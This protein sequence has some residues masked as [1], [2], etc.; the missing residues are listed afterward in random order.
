MSFPPMPMIPPMINLAGAAQGIDQIDDRNVTIHGRINEPQMMALQKILIQ[1]DHK[2]TQDKKAYQQHL[3]L[4][5]QSEAKKD[6]KEVIVMDVKN[7][8]KQNLFNLPNLFQTFTFNPEYKTV[9][10]DPDSRGPLYLHITTSGGD[11]Y[12]TFAVLDVIRDMTL[13]IVTVAKGKA[14]SA[15][16]LLLMAAKNRIVGPDS[17]VL[18]HEPRIAVAGPTSGVGQ[19]IQNIKS[20]EDN[21]IR[22][23]M[24]QVGFLDP[25]KK[26]G[27]LANMLATWIIEY[28]KCGYKSHL[29]TV[30]DEKLSEHFS[31]VMTDMITQTLRKKSLKLLVRELPEDNQILGT[32]AG[33]SSLN[34]EAVIPTI[35]KQL[36]K[37][38]V[39]LPCHSCKTLNV[40]TH[41]SIHDYRS[42]PKEKSD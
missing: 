4:P 9:P 8:Q 42:S 19:T 41:T 28:R 17:Y 27:D 6:P 2:Y 21:V 39:Q 16:A 35:L 24:K 31:A 11:A 14:F 26:L 22:H 15:G 38:D 30:P 23:L 20:A 37:V 10:E 34:N 1:L 25:E 33:S 5:Q 18:L 7:L 12:A 32:N 3:E 40:S 29:Q 36:M 13:P